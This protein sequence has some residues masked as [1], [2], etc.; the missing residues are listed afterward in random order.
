M[1]GTTIKPA[2]PNSKEVCRQPVGDNATVNIANPEPSH[3]PTLTKEMARPRRWIGM[4]EEIYEIKQGVMIDSETPSKMRRVTSVC[5]SVK[6]HTGR[7]VN[8]YQ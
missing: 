7:I 1:H 2:E 6:G 4:I 8:G 3:L 5:R